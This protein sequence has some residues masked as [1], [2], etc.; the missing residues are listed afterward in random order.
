M[1]EEKN[2]PIELTST[3]DKTISKTKK[4]KWLKALEKQSWQAELLISGIV[5]VSLFGLPDKVIEYLIPYVIQSKTVSYFVYDLISFYMLAVVYLL[6]GIFIFHFGIRVLW[7]A[8]LGLNSVYPK[9]IKPVK[10]SIYS[11]TVV[12]QIIK[13]FPNLS[14]YNESLDRL[15]SLMFSIAAMATMIL[16]SITFIISMFFLTFIGLSKIFPNITDYLFPFGIFFYLLLLL[17]SILP[18]ILK[19]LPIK[20][21]KRMELIQYKYLR[22]LSIFISTFFYTPV[23]YISN[24]LWSNKKTQNS[25]LTIMI[26]SIFLG[27]F[28]GA[29][30]H[31]HQSSLK[32][33]KNFQ[34]AKYT[35]FN[36]RPDAYL[37]DNYET[38]LSDLVPIY[39]PTIPSDII[40]GKRLKLFIP[41]I[42]RETENLPVIPGDS[43]LERLKNRNSSAREKLQMLK[44]ERYKNLNHIYVN[45]SLYNDISFRFYTHPNAN[46]EGI[47]TYIPTDHFNIGENILE[48]KKEYYYPDSVQ[49]I[50]HIPF[51][52]DGANGH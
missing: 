32:I 46:E 33:I 47:L 10:F 41:H 30:I 51:Y 45:D 52:F 40:I 38:E 13:E 42:H 15:G 1:K 5:I 35:T 37:N 9:G 11:K 36:N 34:P 44:L 29:F 21:K 22:Y 49:K 24:T 3:E 14:A 4:P 18:S 19:Y 6:I 31:S 27:A 28:M 48:I 20:N 26:G 16:Y 7:I 43:F 2:T 25:P 39:T 12:E 8:L 23:S 50:V 17:P